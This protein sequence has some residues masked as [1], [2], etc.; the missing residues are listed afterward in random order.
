[1]KGPERGGG[2]EIPYQLHR[3]NVLTGIIEEKRKEDLYGGKMSGPEK[4][5]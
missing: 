1:M 4:K 5:I 3:R 2:E